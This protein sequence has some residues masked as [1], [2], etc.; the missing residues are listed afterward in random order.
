MIPLLQGFG[1]KN[2]RIFKEYTYFDF[3]PI[4]ILT[5]PNSSGKSSLIKALRLLKDNYDKELLPPKFKLEYEGTSTDDADPLFW[6]GRDDGPSR[7]ASFH[8]I[9]EPTPIQFNDNVHGLSIST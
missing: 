7:E 2:F 1:L 5:G 3:A 6:Q 8:Q 9:F 4:T